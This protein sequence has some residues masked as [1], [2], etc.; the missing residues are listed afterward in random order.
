MH[1]SLTLP[2]M[3]VALLALWSVA[4]VLCTVPLPTTATLVTVIRYFDNAQCTRWYAVEGND[5]TSSPNCQQPDKTPY[6]YIWQVIAAPA[7][8][9]L[10]REMYNS[11][12]CSGEPLYVSVSLGTSNFAGVGNTSQCASYTDIYRNSVRTLNATISFENHRDT[13]TRW[14]E[15][16]MRSGA[17]S[18]N[19]L[20]RGEQSR[21]VSVE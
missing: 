16:Y 12:D 4:I 10:R 14:S 21:A 1:S 5:W 20:V 11:S 3:A 15:R 17:D 7:Y 9:Y 13:D 18:L 8:T 19:R 6:S 2:T